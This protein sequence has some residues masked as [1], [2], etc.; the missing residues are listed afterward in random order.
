MFAFRRVEGLP[1]Y[2]FA[3]IRDL[4][5]ELRRSG[6]DVVDPVTESVPTAPL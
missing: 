4:T 3:T 2:V 6:E 5:L 1:P